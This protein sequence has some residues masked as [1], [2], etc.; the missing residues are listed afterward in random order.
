M[1]RNGLPIQLSLP[2]G[3]LSAETRCGYEISAKTKR[4]WAVELDLLVQF[5]RVCS[6]YN[7]QY[8]ALWGTALG[9][10]RHRGFIPWD[11]DIDVAMD[12][13]N[14]D[15]LCAVAG[16]E[17]RHP[18]FFQNPYTDKRYFSPL[19][20]LRNSETTAAIKGF[21]TPDYNN[22]IYIDIDI[23]DGMADTEVPW[24]FQNFLKHIA[25]LPIKMGAPFYGFWIDLY[26]KVRSMYSETSNRLGIT[27]S[28]LETDRTSW[29]AKEDIINAVET[30]FEFLDIR[31][32]RNVGDYLA[33][34]FGEWR[35]Y[36]SIE[37]RG[38]WHAGQVY[39]DPD[40]SYLKS[41]ENSIGI[42]K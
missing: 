37:E 18:Y 38:K 31:I 34:A 4:I 24:R 8:V 14:Y 15:K 10:V 41:L 6:K 22:G 12:R 39:F 29:V 11:D 32:P 2:D 42:T 30:N 13:K 9:A 21:D 7:I 19:A 28:F 17:F 25:L 33:R 23:L 36:P 40:L 16:R 3:F 26:A 27:Y 20:R 35:C 5:Q 1:E